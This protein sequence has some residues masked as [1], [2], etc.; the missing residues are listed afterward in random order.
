[1]WPTQKKL[2]LW[3]KLRDPSARRQ[4]INTDGQPITE[5]DIIYG[6]D[7]PFYGFQRIEG[8]PM[9][10]AKDSKWETVDIAFKR[11]NPSEW[12]LRSI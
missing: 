2:R 7:E 1:M 4:E 5:L 8:G 11:G 10:Q 9:L 6:D 3:Y 12:L